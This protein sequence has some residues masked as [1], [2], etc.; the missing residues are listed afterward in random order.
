MKSKKAQSLFDVIIFIVLAL[1]IVVGFV[2]FRFSFHI[3][4]NQFLSITTPANS[5]INMTQITSETFG[6]V[7]TAMNQLRFIAFALIFG[8][9]L[10]I[11]FSNFLVK[12]H[13]AFLVIYVLMII[14]AI[15]ISVAVSNAYSNLITDPLLGSAFTSFQETNYILLYLPT[16]VTVIGF[17]GALI[18]LIGIT[19][20]S[21]QGGFQ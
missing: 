3:I 2:I 18:L 7:D 13:P 15:I 14:I 9:I 21:G 16:V 1:F 19:R 4:S 17:I 8:L 12:N 11:M 20:D 5:V 6:Q 10:L